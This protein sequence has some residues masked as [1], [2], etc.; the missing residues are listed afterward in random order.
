MIRHWLR[1]LLQASPHPSTAADSAAPPPAAPGALTPTGPGDTYVL[2]RT[3]QEQDRL[4]LQHFALRQF[5]GSHFLAPVR[6][7]RAILD[8][9]TGSGIWLR[10]A[11][12]CWPQARLI[13]LDKDLSLLRT[14]LPPHCQPVQADLLS[15]LPFPDASFDY[16]H[17]RLLVAAIPLTAWP[18]VLSDLLRVT[19][20]GGWL[21]FVEATGQV[22]HEGPHQARVRAWF[23]TLAARRGLHLTAPLQIPDWLRSLGLHPTVRA[24]ETPL[25]GKAYGAPLFR[26]D[27]LASLQSVAPILASVNQVPLSLVEETL[28]ALPAEWERQ[29]TCCGLLTVWGCKP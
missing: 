16:I 26:R 8:V 7:P 23:E 6:D 9:G 15:G 18:G 2:P 13:A 25:F 28:S 21:E 3:R 10:E 11:A 24:Y 29:R 27:L 22:F 19:A 5:L 4:D 12:R 20:P 14:P 1:H 17:Q